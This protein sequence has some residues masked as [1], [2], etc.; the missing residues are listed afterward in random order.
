MRLWADAAGDWRGRGYRQHAAMRRLIDK[1]GNIAFG[2]RCIDCSLQV[3]VVT[4]IAG[5]LA[6]VAVS[7]DGS[8]VF[9]MALV[10]HQQQRSSA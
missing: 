5:K 10:G 4:K 1:I 9:Y 8:G 6:L 7:G 3:L 2:I